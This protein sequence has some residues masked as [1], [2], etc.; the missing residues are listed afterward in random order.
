MVEFV[1]LVFVGLMFNLQYSITMNVP[2]AKLGLY[3]QNE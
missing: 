3:F 2:I 1:E